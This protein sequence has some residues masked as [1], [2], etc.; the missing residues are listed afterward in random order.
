MVSILFLK[1]FCYIFVTA[2]NPARLRSAAIKALTTNP[3]SRDQPSRK[4]RVERL[5][6]AGADCEA[7]FFFIGGTSAE[8][9]FLAERAKARQYFFGNFFTN[10]G[11]PG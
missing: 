6:R 8:P 5:R 3:L 7:D 9:P 11:L 10:H 1:I 2:D 4:G